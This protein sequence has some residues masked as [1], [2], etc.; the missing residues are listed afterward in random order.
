MYHSNYKPIGLYMKNTK[1]DSN[2][3]KIRDG[4]GIN[5]KGIYSVITNQKISFYDVSP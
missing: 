1:Q 2:F 4:V 5:E 3:L